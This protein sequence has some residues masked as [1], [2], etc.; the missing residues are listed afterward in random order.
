MDMESILSAPAAAAAA[1]YTTGMLPTSYHASQPIYKE[2]FGAPEPVASYAEAL[3]KL[4]AGNTHKPTRKYAYM[5][6]VSTAGAALLLGAAAVGR[7][8]SR[9]APAPP[10]PPPPPAPKPATVGIANMAVPLATG[11]GAAYLYRK[12]RK[13]AKASK[14][15][16]R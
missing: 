15:T 3:K 1:A 5:P 10:P 12:M 7:K 9:K 11:L 4:P 2:T 6:A 14:R 16:S 13:P 8:G